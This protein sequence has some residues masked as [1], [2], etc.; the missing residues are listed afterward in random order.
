MARTKKK[1]S[2]EEQL[3]KVIYDIKTTQENLKKLKKMKRELEK[4]LEKEKRIN[5][6]DRL[7]KVIDSEGIS[8]EE[9]ERRLRQTSDKI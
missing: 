6:L 4:E 8:Y 3:E 2:I 1:K 5:N 9:A 7:D